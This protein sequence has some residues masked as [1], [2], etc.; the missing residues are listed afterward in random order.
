MKISATSPKRSNFWRMSSSPT[1]IDR[2]STL[3][4]NNSSLRGPEFDLPWPLYLSCGILGLKPKPPLLS[5]DCDRDLRPFGE[6]L[7]DSD[8]FFKYFTKK[9]YKLQVRRRKST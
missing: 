3:M 2:L 6:G 9:N 8:I 4:L 5:G 1:L 7:R